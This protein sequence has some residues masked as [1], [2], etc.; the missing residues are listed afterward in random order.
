MRESEAKAVNQT[1]YNWSLGKELAMAMPVSERQ[2][3]A[4]RGEFL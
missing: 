2:G 1:M 3:W 4:S